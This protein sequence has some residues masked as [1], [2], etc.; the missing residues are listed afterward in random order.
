MYITT[1]GLVIREVNYKEADKILTVLT[2]TEGKLTVSA[3][4]ARRKGC[5]Y[6]A[7]TQLLSFSEMT[8]FGNRGR[9]SLNEAETSEQFLGLREDI[10]KLALGSYMAEVLEA[11]SAEDM[12]DP[13]VLQCG[14]NSLY[15]LS[16]G[17]CPPEQVKAVFEL[18]LMCLSGYEPD[19]SACCVCGKTEPAEPVLNIEGGS[20]HCRRC[21]M[22]GERA[23][24]QL[25]SDSLAAMRHIVLA[26][27]KR[28]FSYSLTGEAADRLS[29]ACEKYMLYHTGRGYGSLDYYKGLI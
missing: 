5:R 28:I 13:Q 12:P 2:D 17:L 19:V 10:V 14:L 15:A 3:R 7:A 21:A 8:L 23:S 29:A 16:S 25:C 20:I 6:S 1:R 11:V 4:G 24:V 26:P 18:R 22:Q 9:W 27:A